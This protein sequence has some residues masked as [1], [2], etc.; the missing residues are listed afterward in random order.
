MAIRELMARIKS[1]GCVLICVRLDARSSVME[2]VRTE[3]VS[4]STLSKMDL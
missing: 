3:P 4:S 2:S 1:S